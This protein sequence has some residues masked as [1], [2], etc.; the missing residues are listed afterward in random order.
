MEEQTPADEF[1]LRMICNRMGANFIFVKNLQGEKFT[2]VL[3]KRV[4]EIP[5]WH[6]EAMEMICRQIR[7]CQQQCS[8]DK[9]E[10]ESFLILAQDVILWV[11]HRAVLTDEEYTQL[12]TA[13]K[14]T[15]G[16][17]DGPLES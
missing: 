17:I 8:V 13:A 2:E 7:S 3:R 6:P 5:L 10:M 14:K 12:A 16:G 1:M 11:H 15:R 9:L 4:L